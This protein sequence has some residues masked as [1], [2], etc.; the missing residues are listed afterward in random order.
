MKVAVVTLM[1]ADLPENLREKGLPWAY[2]V[3]SYD[4]STMIFETGSDAAQHASRLY[5]EH[6]AAQGLDDDRDE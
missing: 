2:R 1:G 4:G 6:R 3:T 5:R